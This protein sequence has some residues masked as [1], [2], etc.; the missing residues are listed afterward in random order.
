MSDSMRLERGFFSTFSTFIVI[1][2]RMTM[3]NTSRCV[4]VASTTIAVITSIQNNGRQC[5]K[6]PSGALCYP[7][8]SSIALTEVRPAWHTLRLHSFFFQSVYTAILL[9][10]AFF[11]SPKNW[12]ERP[13]L[14][15]QG[16]MSPLNVFP[17]ATGTSWGSAETRGWVSDQV[18]L[19]L[20]NCVHVWIL[21]VQFSVKILFRSQ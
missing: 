2:G 5:L 10:M 16:A 9:H 15:I 6:L 12:E 7:A 8:L 3:K 11:K 20:R 18:Q 19:G 14:G 13:F 4:S 21:F 1:P 17:T